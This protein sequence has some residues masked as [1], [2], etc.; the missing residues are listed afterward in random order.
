[1]E[2]KISEEEYQQ[3]AMLNLRTQLAVANSKI[4]ILELE[5]LKLENQLAVVKLYVKY[6]LT[7][8]DRITQEGKIERVKNEVN[9][10]KEEHE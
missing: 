1:M 5:K 9:E 10:I 6:N 2:E 4:S 8:K 3:L 7:E